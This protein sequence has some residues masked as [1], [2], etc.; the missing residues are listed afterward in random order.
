MV[1][2]AHEDS[3]NGGAGVEI[4]P[5]RHNVLLLYCTIQFVLFL[6]THVHLKTIND[7]DYSRAF[8]NYQ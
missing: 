2:G 1:Y 5:L 4:D 6:I 7:T 3:L 8:K